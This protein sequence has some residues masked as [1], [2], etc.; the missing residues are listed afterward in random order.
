MTIDRALPPEHSIGTIGGLAMGDNH[1]V[2]H[3]ENL[4]C[5]WYI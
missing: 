3:N 2:P 5:G 4:N 1:V